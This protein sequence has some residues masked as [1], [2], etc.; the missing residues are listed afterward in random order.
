[1]QWSLNPRSGCGQALFDLIEPLRDRV[2][3]RQDELGDLGAHAS[4]E[5]RGDLVVAQFRN[6]MGNQPA[7]IIRMIRIVGHIAPPFGKAVPTP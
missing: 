4:C 7:H 2:D 3:C 5:R 1:M 6:A